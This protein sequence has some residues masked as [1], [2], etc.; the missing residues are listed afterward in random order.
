MM[1]SSILPRPQNIYMP[2]TSVSY[3]V[4]K[5]KLSILYVTI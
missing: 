3:F 4:V 2:I 5:L 1:F